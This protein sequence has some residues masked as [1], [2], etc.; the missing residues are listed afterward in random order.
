[1]NLIS[2]MHQCNIFNIIEKQFFNCF[3]GAIT[4]TNQNYFWWRAINRTKV[5]I[6]F[7]FSYDCKRIFFAKIPNDEI[8]LF[9][10]ILEFS[11]SRIWINFFQPFYK[12]RRK[13]GV[14]EKFQSNYHSSNFSI[15]QIGEAGKNIFTSKFREI[16]QDLLSGHSRSKV[17]QNIV[18]SYTKP[19]DTRFTKSFSRLNSY[20]LTIIDFF[21]SSGVMHF[22]KMSSENSN[23]IFTNKSKEKQNETK[24]I[25]FTSNPQ[26]SLQFV[27][28]LC[29]CLLDLVHRI[30]E[31][32]C[33]HQ[34]Q[35][36]E[37]RQLRIFLTIH[38]RKV[39]FQIHLDLI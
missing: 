38:R 13:V 29:R 1:M 17:L 10:Q 23:G 19:S 36:L 4:A 7:I 33:R 16:V 9:I 31:S 20:N 35:F 12:F 26:S 39:C 5:K 27:Q 25:F 18:N 37:L 15:S 6:I 21:H 8:G 14:K 11:M 30:G 2:L 24:L 22:S 3:R 34:K 28:H 32:H